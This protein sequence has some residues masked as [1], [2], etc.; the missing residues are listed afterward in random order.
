LTGPL[1][2]IGPEGALIV[3]VG[4]VLSAVKLTLGP[5]AGARFATVSVAVPAAIEML[6]VPS[7]VMLEIVTMRVAPVPLTLAVPPAVPL[8]SSDT[9]AAL[10][11]L[12]RKFSSAYFTVYFIG[13]PLLKLLDGAL[14]A[15]V[16]GVLST[17]KVSLGPEAAAVFP[18]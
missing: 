6:N 8:V 12:A 16:G 7:P 4:A 1:R 2:A 18:A 3:T 13:P 9:S 10:N 15:T 5:A 14:I 17:M 11:V